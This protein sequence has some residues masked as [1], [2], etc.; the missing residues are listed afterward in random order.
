M[1]RKGVFCYNTENQYYT[2]YLLIIKNYLCVEFVEL[3]FMD[4]KKDGKLPSFLFNKSLG[5]CVSFL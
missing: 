1:L 5:V 4:N 3:Y 2:I